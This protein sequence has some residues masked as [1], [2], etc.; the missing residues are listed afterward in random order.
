MKTLITILFFTLTFAS[1]EEK[2]DEV[3]LRQ[4]FKETYFDQDII[5]SLP[6]YDSLKN[7][8]ILNIDTIFKFR[9]SRHFVFYSNG[10]D[11]ATIQENAH[12]YDFF[13]NWRTG[14]ND[15][16]LIKDV[17]IEN[18][19]AFIYPSVDT[20]FKKLGKRKISGF[21]L[22]TDSTI[23]IF[24]KGIRLDNIHVAHSLIW[25]RKFEKSNAPNNYSRDTLIA[26]KWT[27]EFWVD[28]DMGW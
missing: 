17:N 16:K 22:S 8:I 9:N 1:C 26:P 11:T 6:L 25:K 14:S 4:V 28:Q 15:Q 23:E 24:V 13:Y 27:Y 18:L 2:R 19:P 12:S 3:K 21:S 5:Q 10:K 7:I 20:I